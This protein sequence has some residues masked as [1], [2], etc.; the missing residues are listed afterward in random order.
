MESKTTSKTSCLKALLLRAW[1]ERWSDVQWGI[2]IKTV[3]PRGVSGDV[4]NL[5]DCILQQAVVGSGANQLVLS[6]L[7]HSLSA[8][9]VSHAAVLSRV[10]KFSQF[11]KTHCV[12]SLLDFLE[13]MLPGI[14]CCGKSEETKLAGSVLATTIWLLE[15]VQNVPELAKKSVSIMQSLLSDKFYMAMMCLARSSEIEVFDEMCKLIKEIEAEGLAEIAAVLARID[16]NV[17][18]PVASGDPGPC[19]LI[20][21]W[22]SIQMLANPGTPVEIIAQRLRLFQTLLGISDAR[23]SSELM[24]GSF[25][26]LNDVSNTQHESQWGAFTFIKV[27]NVLVSLFFVFLAYILLCFTF[28]RHT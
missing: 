10:A 7:K 8:Q 19:S 14:T 1:R 17:L 5:A 24:R 15:V 21:A 2:N 11:H 20:Q 16:T 27:P 3:L 26:C 23:M 12:S 25:L 22:L 4:Y 18:A 13:G 9:L 28:D 6:Y